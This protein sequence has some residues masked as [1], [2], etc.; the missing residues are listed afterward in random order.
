MLYP[1]PYKT[2]KTQFQFGA[3]SRERMVGVHPDLIR[4]AEVAL[5]VSVM[6]FGIPEFGG[7]RTAE[8]Q[9]SLFKRGLSKADGIKK[10]SDH[11]SG[12]AL[13]VYAFHEGKAS[14][15]PGH[16]AMVAVAMLT[17]ASMLGIRIGWGGMW[18][19][20]P[21][22]KEGFVDMPHFFLIE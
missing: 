16:L 21:Y 15:E 2:P 14:W 11:Q 3:R 18:G 19:G 12:K 22:R 8:E 4:C 17:A 5:S 6:D 13:D 20:G 10:K 9:S 1:S 7:I